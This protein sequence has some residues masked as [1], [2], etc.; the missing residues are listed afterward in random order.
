MDDDEITIG[1]NYALYISNLCKHLGISPLFLFL[2]LLPPSLDILQC[3]EN[4]CISRNVL[5][6]FFKILLCSLVVLGENLSLG[7]SVKSFALFGS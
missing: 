1:T 3:L 7:S 6:R 4:T 5:Q 2:P